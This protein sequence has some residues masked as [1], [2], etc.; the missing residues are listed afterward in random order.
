MSV[1]SILYC[2]ST[3]IIEWQFEIKQKI[4]CKRRCWACNNSLCRAL[5]FINI[6]NATAFFFLEDRHC[7]ELLLYVSL[8]YI[9]HH[10][11]HSNSTL[12]VDIVIP[13]R[14]N[15]SVTKCHTVATRWLCEGLAKSC[16]HRKTIGKHRVSI[17]LSSC[18]VKARC[19]RWPHE[20]KTMATRT[21]RMFTRWTH[22]GHTVAEKDTR[23]PHDD[24]PSG[25]PS[26]IF[27]HA[28]DFM[29]TPEVA[30]EP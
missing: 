18:G 27:W 26:A 17:V 20:V 4:T 9:H 12:F 21:N 3:T 30:P 19:H 28:K 7:S 22:D 10:L 14:Y 5:I 2:F 8:I 23:S 1:N 25:R 11:N 29:N 6:N 24:A 16:S 15:F 13:S